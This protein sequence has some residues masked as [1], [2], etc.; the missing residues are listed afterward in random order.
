MA[1]FGEASQHRSVTSVLLPARLFV[2]AVSV[3][4]ARE[5][6]ERHSCLLRQRREWVEVINVK[7]TLTLPGHWPRPR[8]CNL[9]DLA[10]ADP[11]QPGE[12][13]P[14]AGRPGRGSADVFS[15]CR[16]VSGTVRRGHALGDRQPMEAG[17][18]TRTTGPPGV[19]DTQSVRVIGDYSLP[20]QMSQL[21]RVG[22]ARF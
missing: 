12:P 15:R 14:G 20:V 18:C 10:C 7:Q 3:M 2:T 11:A 21:H 1:A 8:P 16:N 13:V 19:T 4:C 22:C 17:Q 9:S 5:G 6:Q